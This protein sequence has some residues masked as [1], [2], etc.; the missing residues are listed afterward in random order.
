VCFANSDCASAVCTFNVC[1]PPSCFDS[2]KNG[3]ESDV[4]CGGA[5]DA[6]CV[7]GQAC[8][9]GAD[10]SSGTCNLGQCL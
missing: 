3:S 10:C 1:A 2:A 8:G 9:S 6:K 5:C 7:T 4:D